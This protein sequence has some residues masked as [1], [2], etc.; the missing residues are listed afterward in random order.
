MGIYK[1]QLSVN[2]KGR[3]EVAYNMHILSLV[4]SL[5][6]NHFFSKRYLICVTS[7]PLS[8]FLP[9]FFLLLHFYFM[10]FVAVCF[11]CILAVLA[12]QP[13]LMAKVDPERKEKR[14]KEGCYPHACAFCVDVFIRVTAVKDSKKR[15]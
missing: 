1:S 14:K 11:I 15:N 7:I 9:L 13:S 8:L 12:P 5:R 10:P 4:M 6:K 3:D 2:Y